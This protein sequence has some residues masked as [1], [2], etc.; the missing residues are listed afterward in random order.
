MID[1]SKFS[2]ATEEERKDNERTRLQQDQNPMEVLK[3][4]DFPEDYEAFVDELTDTL[5]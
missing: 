2:M 5:P 1:Q 4:T 3:N